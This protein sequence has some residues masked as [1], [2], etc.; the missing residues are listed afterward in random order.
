MIELSLA[1]PPDSRS[2][3]IDL[4]TVT[5][6]QCGFRGAAVYEE[7]RRGALEQESWEHTGYRL[8]DRELDELAALI[9]SCPDGANPRCGCASHL[10]LGRADESGRWQSPAG[11]DWRQAFPMQLAR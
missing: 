4:Q 7:S 5:C 6:R 10:A 9:G 3:E 2:D 1:L 11:L 8:A